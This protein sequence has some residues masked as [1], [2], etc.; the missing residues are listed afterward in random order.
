VRYGALVGAGFGQKA[1][2]LGQ[3]VG[4]LPL[5]VE[6]AVVGD[7]AGNGDERARQRD[8]DDLAHPGANVVTFDR[9]GIPRDSVLVR[10]GG[11]RCRLPGAPYSVI[12]AVCATYFRDWSFRQGA[13]PISL[14]IVVLD[15]RASAG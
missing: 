9:H 7:L 14:T 6:R 13:A 11:G 4:G 2:D 3:D 10:V 1:I 8:F 15:Q 5:D 12:A